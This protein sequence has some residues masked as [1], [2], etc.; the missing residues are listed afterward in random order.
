[1]DRQYKTSVIKL[2]GVVTAMILTTTAAL[3][4]DTAK[5]GGKRLTELSSPAQ[6]AAVQKGEL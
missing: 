3:A 2:A 6:V 4:S 1:M 5:G